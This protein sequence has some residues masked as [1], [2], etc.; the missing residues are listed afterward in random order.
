MCLTS[1]RHRR[2]GGQA[3]ARARARMVHPVAGSRKKPLK[4]WG[5]PPFGATLEAV[6]GDST[7]AAALDCNCREQLT[8]QSAHFMDTEREKLHSKMIPLGHWLWRLRHVRHGRGNQHELQN[9]QQQTTSDKYSFS[10]ISMTKRCEGH[11]LP[12][13][14]PLCICK[15]KMDFI[16]NDP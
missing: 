8:W 16:Q 2:G 1:A 6:C 14:P 7:A 11:G 9:R 3:R 15:V 13:T 12:R 5:P 4:R 10:S